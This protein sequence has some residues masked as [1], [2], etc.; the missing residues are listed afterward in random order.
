MWITFVVFLG[1]ATTFYSD[2]GPLN[3]HAYGKFVVSHETMD[4]IRVAET[5]R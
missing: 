1:I 3:S 5:T 4:W 2:L